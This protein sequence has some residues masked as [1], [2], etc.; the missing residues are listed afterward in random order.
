ML[1]KSLG[2]PRE[3]PG[4]ARRDDDFGALRFGAL[5]FVVDLRFAVDLVDFFRFFGAALRFV[6]ILTDLRCFLGFVVEA[7]R[8]AVLFQPAIISFRVLVKRVDCALVKR[9]VAA[10]LILA[11][12]EE[13]TARRFG[14]ALALLRFGAALGRLVA[15]PAAPNI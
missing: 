15:L 12:V 2:L 11:F 9:K 10:D 8:L 13:D 5:R 14:A 6:G 1:S 4:P 3:P 7:L